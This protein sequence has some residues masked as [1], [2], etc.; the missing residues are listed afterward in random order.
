MLSSYNSWNHLA[1]KQSEL[2]NRETATTENSSR[3]L[4]GTANLGLSKDRKELEWLNSYPFL[5]QTV[6]HAT[7]KVPVAD[8]DVIKVPC[9]LLAC[10]W[11]NE[12]AREHIEQKKTDENEEDI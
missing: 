4:K 11:P 2:R 5:R 3:L 10:D 7:K 8:M 9:H 12:K 1:S 6:S